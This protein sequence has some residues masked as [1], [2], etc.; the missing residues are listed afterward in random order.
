[1]LIFIKIGLSI[2]SII[3]V[4]VYF[5][6]L[7]MPKNYFSNLSFKRNGIICS[8][9]SNRVLSDSEINYEV[10]QREEH[11]SEC[12]SCR[13]NSRLNLLISFGSIKSH[14]NKWLLSKKS[15]KILIFFISTS[16]LFVLSTIFISNKTYSNITSIC[17]SCVLISYWSLM[18]YRIWLCRKPLPDSLN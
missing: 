17:N 5:I 12:V 3:I 2:L 13:R 15:E 9:C 7:K 14:F 16:L 1:M 8:N 4:A 6:Y 10:F 11:F 18:I